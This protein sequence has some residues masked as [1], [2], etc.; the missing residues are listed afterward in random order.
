MAGMCAAIL[1]AEA[2]MKITLYERQERIGKKILL[3]GNGRCNISH[4]GITEAD[5]RC[6][7]PEELKSILDAFP[8][9][10]RDAFLKEL[11]IALW[12]QRGCLYPVSRQASSV[13]DALRFRLKELCVTICTDTEVRKLN[14]DL[15]L[16]FSGGERS[17]TYDIVILAAGG[18]AGVYGE[19]SHSG[20]KLANG[21]GHSVR[22]PHPG[23]CGLKVTEEL[24]AAAGVRSS[25]AL[26]LVCEDGEFTEE[27]EVQFNRDSLSGIPVM[28]LSRF[29]DNAQGCR[30]YLDLLPFLKE[31]TGELEERAERFPGRNWE[32][33]FAGWLNKK[34]ALWLIS[35]CGLKPSMKV[36]ET[37]ERMR[38]AL[39]DACRNLCFHLYGT[40]SWKE[41][42]LMVG[43]IPLNEL[44]PTLESRK[45]PG[46]YILGEML[47]VAGACGGYNLHFAMACAHVAA[48]S[49][50][51]S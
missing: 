12:E 1:L 3:T 21:M 17:G 26:K 37:D 39:F 36:G 50:L 43:G 49:I 22:T 45:Q 40:A 46:V 23:L 33:Y 30:L 41:A 11:G 13:L 8:E 6:D 28:Q 47:D 14:P 48:D 27:G 7:C 19:E 16:A 15:S 25:C 51:A 32:E 38:A 34:L 5:Y 20:L 42:Q 31:G 29:V 2:G 4:R 9:E 10:R 44:K 24:K 35:S 18:K